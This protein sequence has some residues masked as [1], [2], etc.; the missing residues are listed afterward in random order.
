MSYKLR[1]INNYDYLLTEKK[2]ILDQCELEK[3]KKKKRNLG[4]NSKFCISE[5]LK[6]NICNIY[7]IYI[8]ISLHKET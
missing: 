3:S 1:C 8:I 2:N 7:S 6:N 5:Y 4:C